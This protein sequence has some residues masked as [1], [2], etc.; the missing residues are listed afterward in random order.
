MGLLSDNPARFTCTTTGAQTLTI[1]DL[2]VRSTVLVD[3]GDGKSDILSGSGAMSPGAHQPGGMDAAR[4][5]G[6]MEEDLIVR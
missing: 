4:R 5:T 3:W 6:V 1:E 2:T